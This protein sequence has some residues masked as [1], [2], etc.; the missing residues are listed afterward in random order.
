MYGRTD[1]LHLPGN[2]GTMVFP[3]DA[4]CEADGCR[5]KKIDGEGEARVVGKYLD[6]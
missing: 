6:I 1:E 5:G 2:I 4:S 3:F